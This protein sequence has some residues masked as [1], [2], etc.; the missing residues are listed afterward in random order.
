MPCDPLLR[1]GAGACCEVHRQE[2]K[3]GCRDLPHL[4]LCTQLSPSL[5]WNGG[6]R[7]E[8]S[9]LL[10]ELAVLSQSQKP[11]SHKSRCRKTWGFLLSPVKD[12]RDSEVS[13]WSPSAAQCCVLGNGL[14]F[15]EET[16]FVQQIARQVQKGRC[17]S[18]P[19]MQA[20]AQ[21]L[22]PCAYG[23]DLIWK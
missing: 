2:A 5:V 11:G 23:G 15:P 12:D 8:S 4:F 17:C 6:P 3:L 21:V 1:D 18:Y 20:C 7:Q 22:T 9:W 16:C 14:S 10:G 19:T 13:Q